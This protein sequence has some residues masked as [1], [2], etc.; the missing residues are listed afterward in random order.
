M[1]P[2]AA[3]NSVE[4]QPWGVIPGQKSPSR[5]ACGGAG[6]SC[7]CRDGSV[8]AW[9]RRGA[10]GFSSPCGAAAVGRLVGALRAQPA[11]VGG[12]GERWGDKDRPL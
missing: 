2:A 12:M 8:S 1:R 7:P 5:C 6:A 11:M 10:A 9:A 4:Q 3:G